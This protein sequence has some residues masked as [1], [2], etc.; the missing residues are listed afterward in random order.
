MARRKRPAGFVRKERV[1][2]VIEN[3]IAGVIE[4]S[5]ETNE[6][7]YDLDERLEQLHELED[8]VIELSWRYGEEN[9]VYKFTQKRQIPNTCYIEE[10]GHSNY[11]NKRIAVE[12]SEKDT[13]KVY[14]RF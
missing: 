12:E 5:E 4:W 11:W 13:S 6:R 3:S 14:I 2:E 10:C 1:L 7:F 8:I 9:V